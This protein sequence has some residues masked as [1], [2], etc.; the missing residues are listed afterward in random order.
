MESAQNALMAVRPYIRK[1]SNGSLVDD[2]ASGELCI[3]IASNGDALQARERVQIAANGERVRY[4]VPR[5]GAVLWF[6]VAAV[7]VDAPHPDNAHQLINFLMDSRIAGENSN[8]IHFPNGNAASQSLLPPELT[9]AVAFPRG[10][11]ATR[12]IPE[13]ARSESYVRLRTRMWTRF[14]TGR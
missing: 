1:I 4:S 10:E 12:L 9:N 11:L 13:R 14:R 3:I 5:E 8:A 6:D 2:L 7:P